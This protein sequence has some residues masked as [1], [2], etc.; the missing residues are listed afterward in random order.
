MSLPTDIL[1]LIFSFL[2]EDRT[3][4][5]VCSQS[6][7]TLSQ[8]AER[9]LYAHIGI[10][11]DGA[12]KSDEIQVGNKLTAILSR[13]PRIANYVHSFEMD[14]AY[15]STP[16]DLTLSEGLLPILSSFPALTKITLSARR[17]CVEWGFLPE[18]FRIGFLDSLRLPAIKSV[19]IIWI[20]SFPLSAFNGCNGVKD[21]TVEGWSLDDVSVTPDDANRPLLESFSIKCCSGGALDRLITWA[22]T[23]NLRTLELSRLYH[24]S[25]YG[26]VLSKSF[27]FLTSLNLHIGAHCAFYSVTGR[28]P[29]NF[30]HRLLCLS[31]KLR[32]CGYPTT[33]Q[34][35][36]LHPS[37]SH[38]T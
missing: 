33:L 14:M 28:F 6:H 13:R 10:G 22:P 38:A 29:L 11:S 21:L 12:I 18:T 20:S 4:L 37:S 36:T 15:N 25:D 32:Q 2:Q 26:K 3:A 9:Y 19:S 17:N 30:C 31:C 23:R 35:Y 24:P 34:G 8:L 1:D 7:R 27:D 5:R 16:W